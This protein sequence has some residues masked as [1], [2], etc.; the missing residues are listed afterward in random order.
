MISIDD[1][2]YHREKL[3]VASSA[4]C[5]EAYYNDDIIICLINTNNMT[6]HYSYFMQQLDNDIKYLKKI[7]EHDY[8]ELNKHVFKDP[9]NFTIV[10]SAVGYGIMNKCLKDIQFNPKSH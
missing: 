10:P 5:T 9:L 7:I 1:Y 8:S 2:I 3:N 4:T 6:L